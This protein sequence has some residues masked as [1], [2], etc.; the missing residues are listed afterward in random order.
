MRLL[1][2][3]YFQKWSLGGPKVETGRGGGGVQGRQSLEGPS[4]EDCWGETLYWFTLG[5]VFALDYLKHPGP[6]P[7]ARFRSLLVP[8]IVYPQKNLLMDRI[9]L[10]EEG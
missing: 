3:A 10:G 8:K 7:Q 4:E 2:I 6:R 5:R 1:G 9:M